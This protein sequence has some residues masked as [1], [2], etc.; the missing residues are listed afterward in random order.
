MGDP[1]GPRDPWLPRLRGVIPSRPRQVWAKGE[2]PPAL[3]PL[4]VRGEPVI[5]K[6]SK[7]EAK[8]GSAFTM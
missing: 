3:G 5:G 8:S 2:A 1:R 4:G 6:R 7:R